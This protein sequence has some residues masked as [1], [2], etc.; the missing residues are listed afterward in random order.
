MF[1]KFVTLLALSSSAFATV[2][3]TSPTASTTFTAGKL[4]TI[5][6][7]DDNSSPSLKDFGPAKV[8]IYV[9]NAQQQTSLQL[10]VP[11][12]DVSTTQSIHFIRFESLSLKDAAAPQYPALAFSAKFTMNSMTGTFSPAILDQ[13]NGQSTAPL[14]G[15]TTAAAGAST[16]ASASLTTSKSA[17]ATATKSSS[18]PANTSNAAVHMKGSSWAGIV[19]GAVVGAAVF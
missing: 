2:F 6:W 5:S 14:A 15:A 19:L 17:T 7:Q 9:G 12:V 11:S 8:S 1:S 13:I 4:A 18:T 16:T 3:I 10:I